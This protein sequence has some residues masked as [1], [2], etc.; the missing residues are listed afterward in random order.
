[1]EGEPVPESRIIAMLGHYDCVRVTKS[2][3][4]KGD[5]VAAKI[6]RL[7]NYSKVIEVEEYGW[8]L[9]GAGDDGIVYFTKQ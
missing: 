3:S 4:N 8:R 7:F 2:I 9:A 5:H 1:M 6:D